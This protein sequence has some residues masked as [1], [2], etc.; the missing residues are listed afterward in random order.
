MVLLQPHL[1]TSNTPPSTLDDDLNSLSLASPFG[2]PVVGERKRTDDHSHHPITLI[3]SDAKKIIVSNREILYPSKFISAMLE[4]DA[5]AEKLK[6]DI[7]VEQLSKILSWCEHY[8]KDTE[9]Q[10]TNG[11]EQPLPL[12][13]D[14]T[15]ILSPWYITFTD[16][17]DIELFRLAYASNYLDITPLIHL[18][19]MRIAYNLRGLTDEEIRKVLNQEF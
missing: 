18:L 5:N 15:E 8:S 14:L 11:Y 4:L 3:S 1:T 6:L 13:K 19:T 7:S 17:S 12:Q 2:R 9:E 16:L 10:N